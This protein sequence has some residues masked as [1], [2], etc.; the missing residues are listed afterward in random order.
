M[1]TLGQNKDFVYLY[2]KEPKEGYKDNDSYGDDFWLLD[3]GSKHFSNIDNALLWQEAAEYTLLRLRLI[4]QTEEQ[5]DWLTNY[6]EQ[7]AET[8]T[9]KRA[10]IDLLE[11][12]HC[13]LRSLKEWMTD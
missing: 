2:W 7:C 11:I 6:T 4:E 1:A 12:A 3:L 5:I 8:P 10:R 9:Q 13:N